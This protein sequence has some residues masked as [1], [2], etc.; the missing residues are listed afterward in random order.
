MTA[1]NAQRE[2]PAAFKE[3]HSS[4]EFLQ[5]DAVIYVNSSQLQLALKGLGSEDP[6]TRIAGEGPEYRVSCSSID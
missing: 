2:I 1:V 6:V 4:L 5:Q 3:L